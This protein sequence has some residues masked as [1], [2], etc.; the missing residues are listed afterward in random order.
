MTEV[1][2]RTPERVFV[3]EYRAVLAR[4]IHDPRDV[5]TKPLRIGWEYDSNREEDKVIVDLLVMFTTDEEDMPDEQERDLD[6]HLLIRTV[7]ESMDDSEETI[8]GHAIPILQQKAVDVVKRLCSE[9][10]IGT[11]EIEPSVFKYEAEGDSSD[12]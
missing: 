2:A 8:L 9:L 1:A 11:L 4:A 12:E 6:G 5:M 10:G 3:A 7:W